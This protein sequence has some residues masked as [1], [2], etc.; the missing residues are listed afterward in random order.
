MFA[1]SPMG[2]RTS[3]G[4][5]PEPGEEET[6]RSFPAILPASDVR[7]ANRRGADA[8]NEEVSPCESVPGAGSSKRRHEELIIGTAGRAVPVRSVRAR[9]PPGAR[10]SSNSRRFKGPWQRGQAIGS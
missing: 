2:A 7:F 9:V 6:D 3:Y 5:E 8:G 10:A 1:V 4:T